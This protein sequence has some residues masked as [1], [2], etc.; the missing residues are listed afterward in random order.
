MTDSHLQSKLNPSLARRMRR[1]VKRLGRRLRWLGGS[2]YCPVCRSPLRRFLGAGSNP[3]N[4]RCPVC[5][6]LGRDRLA[7]LIIAKKGLLASPR[8]RLLHVAPEREFA[9]RFEASPW[10]DYC[11]ADLKDRRAMVCL[12]IT[13]MPFGEGCFDVIY[14][15]HVLEHVPDDAKAISES[16]RVLAPGGW[17]ILQVPITAPE[18]FEDPSITDPAKRTRLFGQDDHV[19]RYGPDYGDRLRKAGF[20]VRIINA[21]EVVSERDIRRMGIMAGEDVYYCLKSG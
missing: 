16:Y 12:D 18:T 4:L 13:A 21:R 15:S 5:G 9:C 2:R 10:I 11:S 19:R 3:A 14:C 1:S 17:S 7:W 20:E 6:S 8:K